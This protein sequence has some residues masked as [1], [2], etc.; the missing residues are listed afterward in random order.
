MDYY[1]KLA[2][3]LIISFHGEDERMI[4]RWRLKSEMAERSLGAVL[5]DLTLTGSASVVSGEFFTLHSTPSF[6]VFC[7]TVDREI[8][9]CFRIYEF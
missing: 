2:V 1:L 4:M 5:T 9:S 8:L 7:V 3:L 6:H